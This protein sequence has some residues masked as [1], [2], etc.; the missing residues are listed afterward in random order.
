[1]KISRNHLNLTKVD[2]L[3]TGLGN[4]NPKSSSQVGLMHVSIGNHW[5]LDMGTIQVG[6]S[7]SYFK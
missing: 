4:S 5:P 1:M 2:S 7:H 6:V 3:K